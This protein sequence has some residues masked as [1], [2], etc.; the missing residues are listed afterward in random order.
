MASIRDI[1][2][3][4]R[5]ANRQAEAAARAA[6]EPDLRDDPWYFLDPDHGDERL[7][8]WMERADRAAARKRPT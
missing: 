8:R 2:G 5:A 4:Q 7:R 6:R 1:V 3:Q